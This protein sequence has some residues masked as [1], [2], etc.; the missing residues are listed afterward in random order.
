MAIV[1][2]KSVWKTYRM[3]DSDVHALQDIT[4][5]FEEGEYIAIMGVFRLRQVHDAEPARLPGPADLRP[6]SA[7]RRGRVATA[8]RPALRDARRPDRL[9]LPVLQPHRAVDRARQHRNPPLLPGLVGESQPRAGDGAGREGGPLANACATGP[10]SSP[11]ASSSASPSRG[12]SPATRSSSW[13][14]S[15]PATSTPPPAAKSSPSSTA[16]PTAARPSSSSR[17]TNPS[18]STRTA[19]LH[20]ADGRVVEERRGGR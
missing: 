4:L 5:S 9:H 8:R 16:F 13:A 20:L 10:R 7:R 18:R 14:T 3:G 2:F 19:S 12:R 6:L 15:P 11:A 17:T 1:E